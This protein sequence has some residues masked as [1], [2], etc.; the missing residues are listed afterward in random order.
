MGLVRES[1]LLPVAGGLAIE[2]GFHLI[3]EQVFIGPA[4]V[5][6]QAENRKA[7]LIHSSLVEKMVQKIGL[8]S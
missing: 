8:V 3:D 5:F 1:H 7:Y 2:G 6:R 4:R